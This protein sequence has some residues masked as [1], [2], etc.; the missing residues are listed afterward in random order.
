MET[1]VIAPADGIV[2]SMGRDYG[3]GTILSVNHSYGLKT[4]YAHLAKVLVKKGQNVKRGQKIALVGNT[5]RT[6][7]THLHYEVHL[8]GVPVNPIN[9]ILN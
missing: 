4:K 9:Y 3:Y 8:N 1:P 6:T 7:G 5:G 2:T